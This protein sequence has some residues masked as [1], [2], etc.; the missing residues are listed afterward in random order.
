MPIYEYFC[1][2]DD[3][4]FEAISSISARDNDV[5]C[6]RCGRPAERIM[7]TTFATMSRVKGLVER[8]PFHHADVRTEKRK[9]TIAPVKPKAEKPRKSKAKTSTKAKAKKTKK[10]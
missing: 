8:V 4:V 1:E 10:R 5:K 2:K 3:K 6:P 9:V 7:P